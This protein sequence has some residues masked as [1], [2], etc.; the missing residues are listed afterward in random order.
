VSPQFMNYHNNYKK[1]YHKVINLVKRMYHDRQ[2]SELI[3]KSRTIWDLLEEETGESEKAKHVP[4]VI[5][6]RKQVSQKRQS[7]CPLLY[8]TMEAQFLN[9]HV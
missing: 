4:I 2:I 3:N 6:N 7:M 8:I 9:Q 5:Y 1:I